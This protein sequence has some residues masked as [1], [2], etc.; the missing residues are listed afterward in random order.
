VSSLYLVI[1]PPGTGK[2]RYL[3]RQAEH[4]ANAHGPNRVVITSMTR[5]AAHEIA[6]R[7]HGVPDDN[8]GTLHAHA[9]RALDR[10]DL[11]ETP[12]ALRDWNSEHPELELTSAG[13]ALEDAPVDEGGRTRGDELHAAVMNH[14]ARLTPRQLWRA[15]QQEYADRWGDFKT[16]TGRL[17]FTDLIE[18][19]HTD[20]DQHPAA[21]AVFL[22]DEAQ[23]FSRLE[24]ALA[25]K[26][27]APTD[28]TVI[29]G[30]PD[31]TLYT[32]RGSD[33]DALARLP[34]TGTR[35]LE[36][37]HRVPRAVHALA[38]QWVRQIVE[39]RD[40]TYRPTERPGEVHRSSASR[41]DVT[42]LIHDQVAG[43]I[44]NGQ[45]VMLL[46]TCGYMLTP[47]LA[48][49][50]AAG[51][52][53]HNPYRA[54]QG[55]WNPLRGAGALLAFLRPDDR[56]WG[57]QARL[58]TWDD[59][60]RW[61]DPLQARGVLARG[62]KTLIDEKCRPDRFGESQVDR[63][64][65]TE[66]I[67]QLLGDPGDLSHPAFKL[68]TAWWAANLRATKAKTST[69]PLEVLQRAG[70]AAL[71]TDPPV[72][73]GTIHSVKG[74]EADSVYVFPD[75]SKQGYWHGWHR[76]G[77]TRDQIVRMMYVALTRA[78]NKVTILDPSGPEHVPLELLTPQPEAI[79]A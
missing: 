12:E 23:D 16:Q 75:L 41:R 79:A 43:D 59:L 3:T 33:H 5:A 30:D 15:D 21:P 32:W 18:R 10:P 52:P 42:E 50:R 26:W 46:T 7:T 60:R 20:I 22:L 70:G 64:A 48:A 34:V 35:V 58:W 63:E 51:I 66:T 38:Q 49:L 17:D 29:V 74:G 45:T 14:R 27:A 71:R 68:D 73:V 69:Y 61:T 40:V 62:A 36:Q 39:R 56:T 28:T 11:A 53:F 4:A 55:A 77:P 37:S 76:G 78:R 1:G 19:A 25:A 72:V 2:T 57:D 6:S 44:D 9:Y 13:Q 47:V 8:I 54:T 65:P 24:L 67:M 31:Q